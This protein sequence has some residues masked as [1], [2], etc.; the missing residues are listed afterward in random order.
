MI[1]ATLELSIIVTCRSTAVK[2]ILSKSVI[3]WHIWFALGPL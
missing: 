1:H 3:G 2:I